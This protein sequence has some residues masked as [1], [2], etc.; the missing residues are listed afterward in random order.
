MNPGEYLESKRKEK[1][2]GVKAVYKATGVGDSTLRSIEKGDIKS[3]CALHL[4]KLAD[5]YDIDV[6][7]LYKSYGY[8][9]NED[10]ESYKKCYKNTEL[11]NE[12]EMNTIQTM[13]NLL[14]KEKE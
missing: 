14:V 12:E 8:L 10:L 13:I 6:I 4:K 2:L 9:D 5:Y 1:K 3:P 11:L 7:P